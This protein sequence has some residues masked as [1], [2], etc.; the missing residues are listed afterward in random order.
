MVTTDNINFL[1]EVGG[2]VVYETKTFGHDKRNS[3]M[4]V[5]GGK[6]DFILAT[7]LSERLQCKLSSSLLKQ[8]VKG[9]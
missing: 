3:W 7:A 4:F 8:K 5:K 2:K 1:S 9:F 6:T